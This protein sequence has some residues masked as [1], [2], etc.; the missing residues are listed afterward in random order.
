MKARRRLSDGKLSRDAMDAGTAEAVAFGTMA[1]GL[2]I[3]AMEQ[4]APA[5]SVT[6]RY[7]H[8]VDRPS[9][10]VTHADMASQAAQADAEAL[11][12]ALP[13]R[14]LTH[15]VDVQPQAPDAEP[16]HVEP[17]TSSSAELLPIIVPTHEMASEPERGTAAAAVP[18]ATPAAAVPAAAAE[19]IEKPAV[20]IEPA[21]P[22][23]AP[24]TAIAG[25]AQNISEAMDTLVD[26]IKALPTSI[27]GL[28][29][30]VQHA[31]DIGA[32]AG[33]M[34]DEISSTALKDVEELSE[35]LG[36]PP[37]D[38]GTI[39]APLDLPASILGAATD[40]IGASH[41]GDAVLPVLNTIPLLEPVHADV[42]MPVVDHVAAPVMELPPLQLGFL[43]Q[44][45]TD[46]ADH[47]D[48]GSH[49]LTSPLHG[50]I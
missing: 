19:H 37:L 16:R 7:G 46:V 13:F 2:V 1:A 8:G 36:G 45:Y 23:I 42:A 17:A 43:G 5:W 12:H 32:I 9:S 26:Q 30:L 47:H 49:S 39:T 40:G 20:A 4:F 28:S 18:A 38:L 41:G 24:E 29:T 11:G 34:V 6:A 31:T 22:P 10:N 44:S 35:V 33:Q 25:I 27:D 50:F 21:P 48:T 15:Q 3:G 14:E